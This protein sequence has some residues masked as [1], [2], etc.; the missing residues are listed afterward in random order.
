MTPSRETITR[1]TEWLTDS[2]RDRGL[3]IVISPDTSLLD[4]GAVDSM[5]LLHLVQFLE[6][7]YGFA[8]DVEELVPENFVTPTT[9]ATMVDRLRPHSGPS[10]S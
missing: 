6:S 7:A 8:I 2:C 5:Q 3:D 4:F 1:I 10:A 9:V